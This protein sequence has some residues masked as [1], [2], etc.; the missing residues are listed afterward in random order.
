[1]RHGLAG[2]R[3]VLLSQKLKKILP[4]VMY[5]FMRIYVIN[6]PHLEG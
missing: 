4:L 5:F 2:P 6:I 1:M 3:A